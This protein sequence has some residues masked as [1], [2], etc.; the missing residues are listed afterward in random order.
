MYSPHLTAIGPIAVL[1]AGSVAAAPSAKRVHE[2]FGG[3][4]TGNFTDFYALFSPDVTWDT[5]GF[6][7]RNYAE[8][9]QVFDQ[10]NCLLS[11]PPMAIDTDL[12]ISQGRE[13]PFTSVQAHVP[14][15][16]IGANGSFKLSSLFLSLD[17][18]QADVPL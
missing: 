3:L 4:A 6:G 16:Y 10:I 2:L 7:V 9:L 1:L 5:I 13:G 11:D 17:D 18:L 14:N 15:G 12:V 8:I